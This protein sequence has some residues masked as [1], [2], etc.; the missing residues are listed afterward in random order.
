MTTP[1]K[2]TVGL[3]NAEGAGAQSPAGGL[4]CPIFPPHSATREVQ[5]AQSPAGGLG[6]SPNYPFFSLSPLPSGRGRGWVSPCPDL[7]GVQ[8]QRALRFRRMASPPARAVPAA[9]PSAQPLQL[10][11]P[12]CRS[13]RT[14]VAAF[15]PD[16]P[17]TPPPGW[18]LAPVK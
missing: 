16:A 3:I 17:D 1:G 10:C 12:P 15:R 9:A 4:G 14:V 8:G 11:V 6:V 18:V 5:G 7:N 13:F 2:G